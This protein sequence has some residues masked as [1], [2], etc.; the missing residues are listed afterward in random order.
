LP[1]LPVTGGELSRNAKVP[2]L[3]AA[4]LVLGGTALLALLILHDRR[5]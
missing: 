3:W 4:G 2:G 5:G 1:V